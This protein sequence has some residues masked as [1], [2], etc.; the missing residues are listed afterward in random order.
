[1]SK[2]PEN[3]EKSV[4]CISTNFA[5]HM[6]PECP[7]SILNF[8]RSESIPLLLHITTTYCRY[9]TQLFQLTR[10]QLPINWYVCKCVCVRHREQEKSFSNPWNSTTINNRKMMLVAV[11]FA[12][13]YD[14]S[15]YRCTSVQPVNSRSTQSLR[16]CRQTCSCI[17]YLHKNQAIRK[18][19]SKQAVCQWSCVPAGTVVEQIASIIASVTKKHE[20]VIKLGVGWQLTKATECSLTTTAR[21]GSGLQD[22]HIVISVELIL[23][24]Q[25]LHLL[26]NVSAF[27]QHWHRLPLHLQ[28]IP[29]QPTA[30]WATCSFLK[31]FSS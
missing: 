9:A 19:V 10:L 2:N 29:K 6:L 20:A 8:R 16:K 13:W 3:L 22:P 26:K 11:Q 17:E 15:T 1:M 18:Y 14:S 25:Q 28:L 7:P 4:R 21:F 23:W 12:T 27:W 5:F 30:H 24:P 31:L